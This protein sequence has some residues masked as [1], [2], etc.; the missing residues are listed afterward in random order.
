MAL[1][2]YRQ[3]RDLSKTL[4]PSGEGSQTEGHRFVVQKHDA[5]RLH[6][7]FRLEMDGVLKSW[8]VTKGPSLVPSEKRLAVHVE[9]HPLEYGDFEGTI[10]GGQ[11][12]GGTVVVWDRGT[13][14]PLGDPEAGLAKG[15][16]DFELH[17]EKLT[18]RWHLIRMKGRPRDKRD[19]WLLIKGDDAAVRSADDP[20]ILQ[21]QPD[22]VKTGRT[23]AEIGGKSPSVA[24][25]S[26]L[27]K[28]RQ[29]PISTVKERKARHPDHRKPMR[30]KPCPA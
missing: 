22:S 10:P 4:E 17:G 26:R 6:Y 20:D 11:Y 9:D 2:A 18:G 15:H 3:K 25:P 1:E 29:R 24:G 12:G 16:L 13:W 21:E 5:R 28:G 8:A 30:R 23:I 27:D 7:D 19:N 14:T